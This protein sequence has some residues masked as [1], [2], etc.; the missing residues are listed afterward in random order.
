MRIVLT[1][2]KLDSSRFPADVQVVACPVSEDDKV[3]KVRK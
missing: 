3:N 1:E 2:K